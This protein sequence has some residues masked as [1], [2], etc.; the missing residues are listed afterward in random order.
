MECYAA[1]R[2]TENVY[3]LG[4]MIKMYHRKKQA[5]KMIKIYDGKKQAT[6]LLTKASNFYKQKILLC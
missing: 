5:G 2:M 6:N 1:L 4:K 3:W